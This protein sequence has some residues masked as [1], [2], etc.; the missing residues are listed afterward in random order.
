MK[1]HV[2]ISLGVSLISGFALSQTPSIPAPPP[3]PASVTDE[4]HGVNLSEDYRWLENWDDPAVK[5]WS[6]AKTGGPA[7]TSTLC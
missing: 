3:R 4:Y 2:S 6:A 7:R 1:I 5:Q